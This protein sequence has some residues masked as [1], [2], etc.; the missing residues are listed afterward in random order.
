MQFYYTKYYG[1]VLISNP[2]S[3]QGVLDWNLKLGSYHLEFFG[4]FNNFSH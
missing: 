1:V 2:V 4:D 3:Y